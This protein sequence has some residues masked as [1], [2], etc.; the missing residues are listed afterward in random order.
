M[1]RRHQRKDSL[2]SK[3]Q[4]KYSEDSQIYSKRDDMSKY[5]NEYPEP[6]YQ[7]NEPFQ[8]GVTVKNSLNQN[9][10]HEERVTRQFSL[11]RNNL[12]RQK[13]Y[14]NGKFHVLKSENRIKVE[15]NYGFEPEIDYQ[16][17]H[18]NPDKE[19][20]DFYHSKRT[21]ESNAQSQIEKEA[22]YLSGAST[23][24]PK[25]KKNLPR[26]KPFVFSGKLET[27]EYPFTNLYY[28]RQVTKIYRF[29]YFLSTKKLT[30]PL[31]MSSYLKMTHS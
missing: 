9:E 2:D 24:R 28:A 13:G 3:L 18:E 5:F 20:S 14:G 29:Y 23:L 10:F 8:D 11:V 12:Q 30:S 31:T 16:E 1:S 19:S 22:F 27:A 17:F 4:R 15:E 6:D 25:T 26:R 7:F 21:Y